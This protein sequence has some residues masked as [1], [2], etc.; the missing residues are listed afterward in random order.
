MRKKISNSTEFKYLELRLCPS[1]TDIVAAKN[2]LIQET[3]NDNENT[4]P[5]KMSQLTQK[6]KIYFAKEGYGLV[7]FSTDP[8]QNVGNDFGMMLRKKE[9]HRVEFANGIVRIQSPM[10]HTDLIEYNNV[11]DP[12]FPLL[13]CLSFILPS[14]IVTTGQCKN[15]RTFSNLQNLQFRPLLKTF[16]ILFTLTWEKPA[17]RENRLQLSVSLVS[18]WC[19]EKLQ[20]SFLT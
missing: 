8:G 5:V 7:C 18:I 13:R 20:N 12:K 10:I 16:F 1:I 6:I 9:P 3:H 2:T 11:C 19:S 14:Q 15:Y 4:I 17:V